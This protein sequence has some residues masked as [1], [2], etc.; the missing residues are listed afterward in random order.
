[1]QNNSNV[2]YVIAFWPR[3]HCA[4]YLFNHAN[5]AWT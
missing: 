4:C 5:W 3:P 1:M 2:N